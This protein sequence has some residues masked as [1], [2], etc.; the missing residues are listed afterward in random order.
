MAK[1]RETI[2]LNAYLSKRRRA[3]FERAINTDD[4]RQFEDLY[5]GIAG[6]N[7]HK[8]GLVLH[9]AAVYWASIP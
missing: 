1:F 6:K 3:W 9:T 8:L 5:C 2:P 7:K 4:L